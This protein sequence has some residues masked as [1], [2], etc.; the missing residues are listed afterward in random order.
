[1]IKYCGVVDGGTELDGD[2]IGRDNDVGSGDDDGGND[3][4]GDL[5]G[6]GDAV[7]LIEEFPISQTSCPI[8]D[9]H[10]LLSY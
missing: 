2:N 4:T 5:V 7:G 10:S 1:M 8:D 9:R 6:T 3:G